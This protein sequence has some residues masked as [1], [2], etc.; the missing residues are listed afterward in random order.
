MRKPAPSLLFLH[1][2][3]FNA[4]CAA[5]DLDP[6]HWKSSFRIRQ[7]IVDPAP[8]PPPEGEDV[9]YFHLTPDTAPPLTETAYGEDSVELFRYAPYL[10]RLTFYGPL[11]EPTAWEVRDRLFLDGHMCPRRIFRVNYIYPV[12]NPDPP[13]LLWEEWQGHHR[14]RADLTIRLRVSVHT[15][16][17]RESAGRIDS[18][19]EIL[20]EASS[21]PAV[22]EILPE[23]PSAPADPPVSP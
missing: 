22:P 13:V 8:P 6:A 7:A 10:L 11:A 3:A 23:A 16:V 5:L 1:H 14:L 2:V 18:P 19:P 17:G 20:P 15:A 21:A 4:L 9:L 12:P